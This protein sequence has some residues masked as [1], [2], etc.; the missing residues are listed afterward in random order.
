VFEALMTT[1][2]EQQIAWVAAQKAVHWLAAWAGAGIRHDGQTF[3]AFP[4]PDQIAAATVETLTPLKITFRRMRLMI[5]I[6]GQVASGTLDLERLTQGT[7]D[8]A[9][10]ALTAVKGIGHWT[11]AWT[12]TRAFGAL[13][14]YVGHNDVALQAAV[15]RY[16]YNGEGKKSAEQTQRTFARYGAFGGLAA[17]YTVLRWVLEKYAAV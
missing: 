3:Y 1:I 17:H 14:P 9:Y 2:I 7:Y 15:N 13:H 5:D 8:E 6:A 10:A 4:T 11:A 12:L 16:F